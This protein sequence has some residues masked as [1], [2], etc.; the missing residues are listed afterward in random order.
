MAQRN[1]GFERMP[2]ETYVTPKWVWEALYSVEPWARFAWDCAPVDADFD[3]LATNC[4]PESIAT[5]PPY[6]QAPEFCRHALTGASR[7]A[8]LLSIHF[9]SAHGRRDLFADNP[10]FKA[11]YTLIRRIRWDNLVQSKAGPS[12]NHAWYVWDAEHRGPPILGWLDRGVES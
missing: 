3:F 6:N 12:Q 10:S 11:K 5:N 1:S 9:D 7:V 2:R 8:M 4:P